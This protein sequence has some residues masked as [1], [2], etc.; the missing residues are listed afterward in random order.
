[1]TL[2]DVLIVV[3]VLGAVLSCPAMMWIQ[4]R[5]G[6]SAPCCPPSRADRQIRAA[7]LG[8]LRRLET[9]GLVKLFGTNPALLRVEVRVEGGEICALLGGNGACKS[10]LLRILAT[11]LRPTSGRAT[12]CGY[13]IVEEALQARATCAA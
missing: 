3:V 13:D 9:T 1:M 12:I 2:G 7:D 6:R 4:G 10:T 11:L 8:A 5:R